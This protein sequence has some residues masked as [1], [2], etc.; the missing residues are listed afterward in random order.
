M[1]RVVISQPMLF[2]WVGMIEQLSIAD[3]FVCYDDAQFSKGSF[4]NRIQI[5]TSNGSRWMTIPVKQG[6]NQP[7]LSLSTGDCANW[8]QSHRDM[9]R[10][11]YR[12]S[13]YCEDMLAIV[14]SVYKSDH[15]NLCDLIIASTD[16]ILEYFT[17]NVDSVMRSSQMG[18]SG[19]GSERVLKI[20]KHCGGTVY[21]TGHGASAYLNHDEF[22]A[23]GVRVEY[24]DYAKL[25]Y[26][27]LNPPFTPYVSILDLIA[28]TGPSGKQ[29]L[30]PRTVYWRKWLPA[31]E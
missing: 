12:E 15:A 5:K 14:D 20:V 22:E 11:A 29:Y 30:D 7:I 31:T 10:Q 17:I 23:E 25:P 28:N 27:Q 1:K 24:M 2:P 21:Y 19:T 8:K 13:T 26:P 16:A 4:T 9:L 6:L 3:V 18:I